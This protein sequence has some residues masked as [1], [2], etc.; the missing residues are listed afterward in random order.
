MINRFLATVFTLVLAATGARAKDSVKPKGP[1][2]DGTKPALTAVAGQ[3]IYNSNAFAY[4]TELSDNVGAR[5]T[6][7]PEARKAIDWG[8]AKMNAIGLTNVHTEKWS[9]WKGW[10]RGTASAELTAP[11]HRALTVDAMGWTGSTPVSGVEAEVVTAN[12]FDMDAEIANINRFRGK[13]VMMKPEG[14]PKKNFWMLFAQYG[15]FLKDLNKAGAVAVIGG[16]GGFKAEG[17]HLTHTGIL[18]FAE[19]FQIPVVDMSMEDEGQLERFLASGKTVRVRINVQNTFTGGPVESAN[20]V[21]DI[22]GSEHPEEIVV[23][24]AH[25]DSWDLG[26][27]TTDNGVGTV[28][29]LAAADAIVKSGQRPRR[30]IRFVLFTGEEQGLL[31]SLAY[32]KQHA[33]EMKDHLGSVVLDNGQGPVKEF[34]LGGRNDLIDAMKPFAE[35]LANIREI[36]VTD[37]RE[38]GSDT[39]PFILAGLPGINLDQDS[40]DYKYTHH[41]AA[42]SLEE[43]KP[44]VLTQDATIMALTAFWLADRPERFASPWPAERSAKMLREKGDYDMLKSFNIWPFGDLG[45]DSPGTAN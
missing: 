23:V 29:V 24:G 7:S 25:L 37:K 1:D 35:S 13:I 41:S 6:G 30:T 38:F 44:E 5:V 42:D 36:N 19:D 27:G 8:V 39:G 33:A 4:L 21:G 45:L 31:G 12:L 11:L 43:V 15:D 10:M 26:E 16:Q 2:E 32:V 14:V 28:C 9:M 40:P 34:Q 22:V 3:G 20:V 18:G 17:M